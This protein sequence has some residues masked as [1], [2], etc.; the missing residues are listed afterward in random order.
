MTIASVN[1]L[2]KLMP[3]IAIGVLS[4]IGTPLSN[5]MTVSISAYSRLAQIM[6]Q[7]TSSN[8]SIPHKYHIQV[9]SQDPFVVYVHDFLSKE[10][11]A[12][13]RKTRHIFHD[14]I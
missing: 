11:I 12:H 7:R 6:V 1:Q 5:Y 8:H 14:L 13:F 9:V 2:Y 3:F 4:F 10:E